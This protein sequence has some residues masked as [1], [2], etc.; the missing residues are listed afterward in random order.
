M[1]EKV[2]F[3]ADVLRAERSFSDLCKMYDISRK[4]GYKWIERF[5]EAG[6]TGLE[7]MSRRP[8]SCSHSTPDVIVKQVLELRFNTRHG[9]R[10][11]CLLDWRFLNLKQ[12]GLW[13]A[14]SA[15]FCVGP[16]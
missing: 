2:K 5:Q 6:P 16:A 11:S 4:T 13:R 8:Q 12:H 1:D 7:N 15:A 14:R 3:L 9:E 10:A